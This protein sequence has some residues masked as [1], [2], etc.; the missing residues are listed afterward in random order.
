MIK[1]NPEL[2]TG[3]RTIDEQHQELFY[4]GERIKKLAKDNNLAEI[5]Q[6]YDKYNKTPKKEVTTNTLEE[7]KMTTTQILKKIKELEAYI[8]EEKNGE[9]NARKI[10]LYETRLNAYKNQLKEIYKVKDDEE[11]LDAHQQSMENGFN[12]F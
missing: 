8:E 12:H 11:A 9:N 4:L 2:L 3:D 6:L 7:P 5:R 1:M 10:R